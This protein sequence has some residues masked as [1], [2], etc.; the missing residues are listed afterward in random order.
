MMNNDI[1]LELNIYPIKHLGKTKLLIKCYVQDEERIKQILRKALS[2]KE[3]TSLVEFK[4]KWKAIPKLIELDLLKK[5]D[6]TNDQ[7]FKEFLIN[8][9]IE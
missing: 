2:N 4:N 6:I 5:E 1:D 9:K 8:K 3:I 7:F